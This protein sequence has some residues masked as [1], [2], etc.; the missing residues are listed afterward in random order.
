MEA[1]Y[2]Y[3][4]DLDWSK[5]E[6]IKVTTLYTLVEDAYEKGV[7][8]ANLLAAYAG[9]KEVVPDKGTERRLGREFEQA[10]GYSIYRVMKAAQAT[11]DGR[12]RVKEAAHD[13][14]GARSKH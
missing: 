6:M 14:R 8:R 10:S 5:S 4:L 2:E 7:D 11:T 13:A 3:P 1:N 12:V 9:F